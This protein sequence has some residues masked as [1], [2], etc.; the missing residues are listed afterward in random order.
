MV[1]A[2]VA[3]VRS[4]HNPPSY[5]TGE[6]VV[7]SEKRLQQL[8]A[9]VSTLGNWGANRALLTRGPSLRPVPPMRQRVYNT[10][11]DLRQLREAAN[12]SE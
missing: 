2:A 8:I 11:T 6:R 4:H 12:L 10:K 7:Y 3:K 1:R 9:R 5:D